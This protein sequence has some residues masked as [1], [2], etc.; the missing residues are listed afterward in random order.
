LSDLTNKA[1]FE[2]EQLRLVSG[3]NDIFVGVACIITF[4]SLNTLIAVDF[5]NHILALITAFGLAWYFV[6][7]HR[8]R[9]TGIVISCSV[10][11]SGL[12]LGFQLLIG[13]SIQDI[14]P[15]DNNVQ[16][17]VTRTPTT[18]PYIFPL[19]I[20]T[21]LSFGFWRFA[22]VPIA[23]A[24][25]VAGIILTIV[26]VVFET[27]LGPI[28]WDDPRNNVQPGIAFESVT[29]FESLRMWPVLVTSFVCGCIVEAY[30]IWWDLRD[31]KRQSVATDVAFWTHV[32]AAPFILQPLY[33]WAEEITWNSVSEV[34]LGLLLFLAV[35]AFA[36]VINR[37][38][39][40][41]GAMV[42]VLAALFTVADMSVAGLSMGVMLLLIAAAWNKTRQLIEPIMPK[43][44]QQR[45]PT[46][47]F[48]P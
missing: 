13:G 28:S 2:Q 48:E 34:I 33:W 22:R 24:L 17:G 30:A 18:V 10:A 4:V 7:R 38:A 44:L 23:H 8:M 5:L 29:P 47:G 14:Q 11:I 26:V 27:G 35:L 31:P 3:Y 40:L 15:L 32:V 37:R 21:A 42:W 9:F 43:F 46:L 25:G 12:I 6:R 41:I 39:L 16:V 20:S 36:L 1:S 45:F 19:L